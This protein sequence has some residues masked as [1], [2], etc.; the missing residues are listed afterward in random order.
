MSSK[1]ERIGPGWWINDHITS[2]YIDSDNAENEF[3]KSFK[4]RISIFHCQKCR[5][6]AT[7]YILN[8]RIE[9]YKGMKDNK[10]RF[11]GMFVYI[12]EMHNWVNKRLD[13]PIIDLD[14]AYSMYHEM[15]ECDTCDAK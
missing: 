14:T 11:I 3:I 10:G 1:P 5:T 4:L 7:S 9:N 8:H 15:E 12:W 13:K 2:A 6:H